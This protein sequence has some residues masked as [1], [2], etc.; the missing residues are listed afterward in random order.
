MPHTDIVSFCESP[1]GLDL[2][3][4]PV[5]R[6][7]LKIAYGLVLNDDPSQRFTVTDWRGKRTQEFTETEYVARLQFENRCSLPINRSS[8]LRVFCFGR[9]S[10]KDFLAACVAAYEAYRWSLE[11][12]PEHTTGVLAV[13]YSKEMS[14]QARESVV[15]LISQSGV[16]PF[17]NLANEIRIPSQPSVQ[18][19]FR[20]YFR[21][22]Q[23][24]GLRGMSNRTVI[25]NEF[26]HFDR[27]SDQETLQA[28]SPTVSYSG[29]KLFL[30]SSPRQAGDIFHDQFCE[31][32]AGS[33]AISLQIPTWE[34]NPTVSSDLFVESY[35]QNPRAFFSEFGARFG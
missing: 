14:A 19:V 7:V 30:I 2:T 22:A 34:M 31:G 33:R 5:Q 6:I 20:M 25:L 26:A 17:Q 13:G 21:H 27:G 35:K 10:G 8:A 1:Q 32:I 3:L 9:R 15:K 23:H 12:H 4:Y 11:S 18:P 29:G 16:L 28:V 24:R